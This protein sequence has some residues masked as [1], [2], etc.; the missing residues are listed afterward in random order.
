[1]ALL[2]HSPAVSSSRRWPALVRRVLCGSTLLLGLIAEGQTDAR[3]EYQVKAV[4]LFNFARFVEWPGT[5]FLAPGDPFVIG[6]LGTDPFGPELESVVRGESVGT[7]PIQIARFRRV[8]DIQRCQILFI[9]ESESNRLEAVLRDL[10]GRPIL[11]VGETEN[12]ALRGVMIR[13]TPDRGRIR[14]RINLQSARDAGL[15]I[16][17]KLL[18]PAEIVSEKAR[19]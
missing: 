15:Q 3:R 17:S 9:S 11:T 18:R 5:A 6:I 2:G 8:S 14:L 7:H 12:Y 10:A 19:S 13:F 16:S 4:F 1:M